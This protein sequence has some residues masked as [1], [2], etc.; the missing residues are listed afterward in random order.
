[1]LSATKKVYVE[2]TMSNHDYKQES[3]YDNST[4]DKNKT[5]IHSRNYKRDIPFSFMFSS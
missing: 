1:V 5:G 2:K 3:T 4:Y